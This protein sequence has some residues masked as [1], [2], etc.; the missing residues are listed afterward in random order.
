[1]QAYSVGSAQRGFDQGFNAVLTECRAGDQVLIKCT[2]TKARL[3]SFSSG[4]P[5][6]DCSYIRCNQSYKEW[7][8][9]KSANNN[10]LCIFNNMYWGL[11]ARLAPE[12]TNSRLVVNRPKLVNSGALVRLYKR[13]DLSLLQKGLNLTLYRFVGLV[14]VKWSCQI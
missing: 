6:L 7:I 8:A 12:D 4:L 11:E 13:H 1:V 10:T 14:L 5:F 3:C 9:I 2:V